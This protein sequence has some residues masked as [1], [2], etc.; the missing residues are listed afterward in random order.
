MTACCLV[1][2]KR[3]TSAHPEVFDRRDVRRPVFLYIVSGH[4]AAGITWQ[5][6]VREQSLSS[7][8][9]GRGNL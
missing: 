5:L 3:F 7:R 4:I 2:T 8:W 1:Q 6:L 9:V